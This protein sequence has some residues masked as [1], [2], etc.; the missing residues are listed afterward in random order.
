[1]SAQAHEPDQPRPTNNYQ[2]PEPVELST[3]DMIGSSGGDQN[4]DLDPLA[5]MPLEPQTSQ[6]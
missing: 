1:M 2:E 3:P 5:S 6:Q 4:P